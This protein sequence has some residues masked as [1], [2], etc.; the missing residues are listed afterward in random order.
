MNLEDVKAILFDLDGTLINVDLKKFIPNYMKLLSEKFKHIIRPSKFIS[1]LL[2]ASNRIDQNNGKVINEE[3]FE[4]VF[5]PLNG[6]SREEVNP[7]LNDFYENDFIKLRIHTEVK[8]D[9]RLV[10]SK[11][12]EKGYEVVIATTPVIPLTAIQQ[13]LEWAGVGDFNY[14]FITSIENMR[15]NKPHKFYYTQIF[16][17]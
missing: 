13:R 7:I 1:L 15:A 14:K 6:Y 8:P 2:E 16:N 12:F 11:A 3:L 17:V 5:F 4:Q 10:V 9:A